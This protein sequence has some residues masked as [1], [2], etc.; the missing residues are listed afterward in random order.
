VEPVALAVELEWVAPREAEL[1]AVVRHVALR[2]ARVPQVVR[3]RVQARRA[4]GAVQVRG[5]VQALVLHP[6]LGQ[7]AA[8]VPV[9]RHWLCRTKP[10][11]EARR[12]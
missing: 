3:L 11:R 1:P 12:T 8:A 4:R 10:A 7:V 2:L 5:A 6:V 9:R